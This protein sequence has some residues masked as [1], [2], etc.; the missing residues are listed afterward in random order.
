TLATGAWS[1]TPEP[2]M[3]ETRSFEMQDRL[4][5][6]T[7]WIEA[8]NGDNPAISLGQVQAVYPVVRLIFKVAGTEGYT[9][10]YANPAAA[11][12]RYDLSLVAVKLLTASRNVASLSAGERN[13]ATPRNRLAGLNGGYI[14][15]AALGLVVIVLLVVVAKL[16][17]KPV[18][19]K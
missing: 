13:P 4:R 14:F 5:T 11:A 12:P 18:P 17:P 16:L 15:W 2:G 10:A 1:R 9:L 3:P 7:V 19:P 8:D 6:D